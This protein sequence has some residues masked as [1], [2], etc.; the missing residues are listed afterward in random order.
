MCCGDGHPPPGLLIVAGT[1]YTLDGATIT[2]AGDVEITNS[3]ALSALFAGGRNG[4]FIT[5][6]I[7]ASLTRQV[8]ICRV[9]GAN[10]LAGAGGAGK[11]GSPRGDDATDGKEAR[12]V[13]DGDLT[14]ESGQLVGGKGGAGGAGTTDNGETAI[15]GR[16]GN[17]GDA[18]V[19]A[20]HINA[21]TELS[22]Q[23]GNAGTEAP[24]MPRV[25]LPGE[26]RL[27]S[28]ETAETAACHVSRL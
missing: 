15:G 11:A 18:I 27:L 22:V 28:A 2:G 24:P 21:V 14:T 13:C 20:G 8:G 1:D 9:I 19:I 10:V 4:L 26:R 5:P 23:A 3:V 17:G 7:L 25:S 12:L 6:S 16:G